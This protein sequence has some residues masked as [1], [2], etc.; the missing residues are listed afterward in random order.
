[1][2]KVKIA[3][4]IHTLTDIEDKIIPNVTFGSTFDKDSYEVKTMAILELLNN[5]LEESE[6]E[7]PIFITSPT[8]NCKLPN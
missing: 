6:K 4:I 2:N 1:M 5:S 7:E 8:H 3:F